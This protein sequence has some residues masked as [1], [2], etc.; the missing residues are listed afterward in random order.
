MNL[1]FS[2]LSGL[3]SCFI[4]MLTFCIFASNKLTSTND[5][6]LSAAESGNVKEVS[7][8]LVYGAYVNAK[9][10]DDAT[11]L[12]FVALSGHKDVAELLISKGADVN[13]KEK[14]GGT[15][16]YFAAVMGRKDVAELLIAKGA[17]VDILNIA[18]LWGD[19]DIAELLI[20]KGADVN[21]MEKVRIQKIQTNLAVRKEQELWQRAQSSQD[22]KT[23]QTYL[24]KYPN[25]SHA[26]AMQDRLAAIAARQE[27]QLWQQA[28]AGGNAQTVQAYLDKYS[29]GSHVAAAQEK[30]AALRN[31]EANGQKAETT[32][33]DCPGCPELAVIPA[34]SYDMGE[35]D[36][37]HRV[38]LKSFALGKTE[39]TQ[40]QWKAIMGNN[41]SNFTS[42]GD[43]CPVEQV[44]WNDAQAFI[45]KLN[46][47]TGKQYRL[48]S[49]AEWEYAC[50]AGGRQVYCG[51]DNLDSVAWHDGNSGN[52]THP[53]AG[54]QA[55]A[56]GLY[57]MSGNVWEWVE[58][59]QHADYNGAPDDGSAWQGDG[60][61]RVLRG[62]SWI[63]SPRVGSEVNRNWNGPGASYYNLGFRLAR[64]LP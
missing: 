31:A 59:S 23:M 27:Q 21:A 35:T 3:M 54:K 6:L 5:D 15:P 17:K 16:L 30:L 29:S 7:R 58:D 48:P 22:A 13:A 47:K 20:A 60:T 46:A 45:Q 40:G 33:R 50:H 56:F 28:Q 11:P 9:N 57:D 43:N 14:Y 37:T 25:G 53:V 62:G 55:N 34:G 1:E 61:N 24:D 39:V 26:A 41:P 42:C 63:V 18:A 49:E 51:S 32:I 36:S 44:S 12:H 38:T 4:L 52:S 10:N 8:Q 64:I 2:K 19:K